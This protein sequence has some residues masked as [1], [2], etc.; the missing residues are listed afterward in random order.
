MQLFLFPPIFHRISP[1][2]KL[3]AQLIGN[4]PGLS[5]PNAGIPTQRDTIVL[6]R[7]GGIAEPPQ[8]GR[9][10][11]DLQLKT[12]TVSKH[13]PWLCVLDQGNC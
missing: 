10:C 1:R 9:T 3:D 11:R 8:P 12:P 6:A 7:G 13:G 2:S 5:Q 4:L